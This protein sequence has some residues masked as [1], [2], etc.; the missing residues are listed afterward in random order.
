MYCFKGFFVCGAQVLLPSGK[1][2]VSRWM[3]R[4]VKSYVQQYRVLLTVHTLYGV[5]HLVENVLFQGVFSEG[6]RVKVV[7]RSDTEYYLLSTLCMVCSA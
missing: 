3:Q 2:I 5:Q 6:S 1:Y 7:S 4:E